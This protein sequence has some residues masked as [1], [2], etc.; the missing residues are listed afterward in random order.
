MARELV[1]LSNLN[2]DLQEQV[3]ELPEI[4]E[5]HSVSVTSW[6]G[7]DPFLQAMIRALIY[8]SRQVQ[9]NL[10]RDDILV[11]GWLVVACYQCN[12]HLFGN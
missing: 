8:Y 10:N 2:E 1:N 4:K 9:E 5:K 3:K 11:K 6:I 7:M 12:N